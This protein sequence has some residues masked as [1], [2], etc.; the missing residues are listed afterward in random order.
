RR[1]GAGHSGAA[2]SLFPQAASPGDAGQFHLPVE[3]SDSGSS[4]QFAISTPSAESSFAAATDSADA[5]AVV[6]F[7]SGCQPSPAAGQDECDPDR[8]VG[9]DECAG[10]RL[11]GNAS[12][13]GQA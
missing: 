11:Q 9:F 4:G 2:D 6:L 7:A 10:C 13:T 3:K 8:P 1:G 5:F 12:R